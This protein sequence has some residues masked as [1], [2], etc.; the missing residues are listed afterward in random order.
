MIPDQVLLP[1]LR[2]PPTLVIARL[3]AFCIGR[4]TLT[5]PTVANKLKVLPPVNVTNTLPMPLRIWT[6]FVESVIPRP[7]TLRIASES[8]VSRSRAPSRV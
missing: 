4:E 2:V 7:S 6:R 1:P 3:W 5:P 8:H